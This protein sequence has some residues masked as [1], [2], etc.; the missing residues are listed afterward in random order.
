MRLDDGGSDVTVRASSIRDTI[1][2]TTVKL[3]NSESDDAA[4]E[5]FDLVS[6]MHLNEP[7][8]LHVLELRFARDRI[9]T[10]SGRILLSINPFQDLPLYTP[11]VLASYVEVRYYCS[12]VHGTCHCGRPSGPR[13]TAAPTRELQI[14]SN[15]RALLQPPLAL[16]LAHVTRGRS[17]GWWCPS[18][19]RHMHRRSLV[20][21]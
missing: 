4:A 9:Y 13:A 14:G 15:K 8:I 1:D 21:D 5:V 2:L 16:Q 20:L 6:L 3:C 11:T 7:S 18:S 12:R 17:R 10:Y 19:R